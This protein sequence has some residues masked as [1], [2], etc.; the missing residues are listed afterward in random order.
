MDGLAVVLVRCRD[1]SGVAEPVPAW[2]GP[3]VVS[4]RKDA[5]AV[6]GGAQWVCS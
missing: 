3:R 4:G 1:P 2:N 6:G 5:V